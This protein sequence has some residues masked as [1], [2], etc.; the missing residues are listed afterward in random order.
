MELPFAIVDVFAEAPLQ[1]NQLA[2]VF[3]PPD[4][5]TARMQAIALEMNFSET[6]FVTNENSDE[7]RVRIFTPSSELPF[8]GHPT[9]GT[10]SVLRARRSGAGLAD[11]LADGLDD[12]PPD[13]PANIDVNL[14]TQRVR[15]HFDAHDMPWFASPVARQIGTCER[16]ELA[17]RLGLS[18]DQ[19]T[20]DAV[21]VWDIGP[22]FALLELADLPALRALRVTTEALTWLAGPTAEF[23]SLFAFTTDAYGPDAH[24]AARMLFSVNGAV[25]EDPATGSANACFA[26]YL[27]ASSRDPGGVVIVEQGFE[28]DRPSRIY[29]RLSDPPQVGGRVQHIAEGVLRLP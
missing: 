17:L 27:K 22:R 19:L 4:L 18:I 11:G 10:A 3:A 1:G 20:F 14:A 5:T 24:Y 6:T 12:R 21:T 16:A 29:L 2:V 15:V 8:A 28:M 26:A 7:E 25:R 13:R 9:L 23:T